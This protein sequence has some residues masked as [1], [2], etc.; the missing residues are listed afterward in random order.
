[1]KI[2][3]DR[4]CTL[5]EGPLW[6]PERQQLFWFDI[7][8]KRML[9]RKGENTDEWYFDESPSAAAWI[10]RDSLLIAF[11]TGL[12]RFSLATSE[13][14]RMVALNH[15]DSTLRTNDGRSDRMGGFWVST[16][17][18]DQTPGAGAIYRYF[19]GKLRRVV[20]NLSVPNAICFSPDGS[21]LYYCDTPTG[22]I[23]RQSLDSEGWPLDA[24]KIFVD[25]SAEGIKPDGSVVDAK[26]CLWNAQWGSN[27]IAVYAPNSTLI[28]EVPVPA[29]Q[30]SCVAFG[31][32]SLQDIYVTSAA[33]NLSSEADGLTYV[34]KQNTK[35]LVDYRVELN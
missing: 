2:F 29:H 31:G 28:H 32:E 18:K 33:I 7:L 5:G 19:K 8:G 24:P 25:V 12:Y 16:M 21:Y 34:L 14:H 27:R 26:G 35:G 9:T 30:V 4:V 13:Q 15:G 10:D 1:M 20:R 23:M 11:E 6:H 17:S 22:K 3:D